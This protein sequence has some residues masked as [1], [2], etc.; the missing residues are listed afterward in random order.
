MIFDGLD[1]L[2]TRVFPAH[3][4]LI[5]VSPLQNEDLHILASLRARGYSTLVISPDA[6]AFEA[7]ALAKARS[8]QLGARLAHLERRLLLERL[9]HAGVQVINWDVSVPFDRAMHAQLSRLQ[10]WTHLLG[11][12]I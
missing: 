10:P 8:D 6:V 7:E 2:P 11:A 5:L 9:W 1:Y 12:R 3:S 4:Q